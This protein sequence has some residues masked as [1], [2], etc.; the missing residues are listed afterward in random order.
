MSA[1]GG[2]CIEATDRTRHPEARAFR[3]LGRLG[4]SRAI[5]VAQRVAA[6]L[7]IALFAG[8]QPAL[9]AGHSL[10]FFGT[11]TG[12]IDRVKIAI[13]DPLTTSPG[14][15]VDVGAGDFTVELWIKANAAENT[16]P[17][18]AC[19]ANVSWRNGNV[20]I[21]RDRLN[22]DRKFGVSIAGA[23]VVFGIS[24][25]TT[26]SLTLCGTSAVLDGKWHHVAVQRRRSDGNL[27]LFVDGNLEAQGVG[28]GG[29]I[30]YPDGAAPAD[31]N[32][33][34]LVL[35]AEKHD[36]GPAFPSFSGWIDELRVSTKL[37][38]SVSFPRPGAPYV[39]DLYTAALYH[40]DEG[41]GA[42]LY[43]ASGAS[44]GP[45]N[46]QIK[47]GGANDGPAWAPKSPFNVGGIVNN[48]TIA[49]ATF[50]TGFTLPVDIVN[51]EDASG[52]LYIVQQDGRI[53]IIRKGVVLP[54]PFLDISAKIVCCGEQGLLGLAFHPN[55]NANGRFFVYYT[56]AG[57]GALTIERYQRSAANTNL[58]DTAPASVKTLLVIPHPGQSN[59]NGG[60]LAFGRDGYLYAGTGDGGSGDDPPNNA[61]MVSRRLGKLL[62]FDVDQNVNAAPYYGIPPTNPFAGNTCD[63]GNIGQCPEIWAYGLRNPWRWSF[64]RLTGDLFIGDVGQGARE[65]VDFDPW[66]GTA[67]RNYGWRIME[68]NICTPGVNPSCSPP[69]NYAPPIFDYPHPTGFAIIGGYRYRGNAIPALAGAYLYADEVT[70]VIWAATRADNGV[71]TAQ[72]QLLATPAN[73]SAFGEANGGELYVAGH[74]NGTIYKVVPRD[75][76]GDGLPDWWELAYTGSVTGAIATADLDGD[77]ANNLAEYGSRTEPWNAGSV[78]VPPPPVLAAFR[79]GTRTFYLDFDRDGQADQTVD[80]GA[81]GGMPG[82]VALAGRVDNDRRY[83]LVIYRDGFWYADLNR[84]GTVDAVF[85][86]G[87]V[88]G[89]DQPLLADLNGDG[90][91]DLVVYRNGAWHV[92]TTQTGAA[93][94]VYYFGGAS[95][96]IALAGDVDG[97]GIADLVIY[98][99][100]LWFIDTNRDGI[101]DIVVGHGGLAG[102]KPVLFDWDGDGRADLCVVRNGT[103]FVNTR[104]DGS[105]QA[106]FGYGAATDTPLAWRE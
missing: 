73:V 82:D 91:D 41:D 50:A 12:D 57:D 72:Q 1:A 93:S 47:R 39:P 6:L 62:R 90:R 88:V 46:G 101:A 63:G 2:R 60:K 13:D 11:G 23:K 64:D 66:P 25:D 9:A 71:W 75:S 99:N 80:F 78:P 85:A 22:L 7:A 33:V 53:R 105:V 67:G 20:V 44:G 87:G 10:R 69:P 43:D 97:D 83:D 106:I 35:G 4:A 98:R 5:S 70:N 26:G 54:T 56:R 55:Y 81:L 19:G 68:G 27:W 58:A 96:D 37:R 77:G 34:F 61:Q 28:P 21:D 8:A 95:G 18:V 102:D 74:N 86:F 89:V 84:D 24:G 30:S 65:E 51:A 76:D 31:P 104:L 38:Y 42:T 79:N 40:F 17:A 103:W 92:S 36:A 29:D 48:G 32:D 100:G 45:S 14:P 52:R 49:L 59:H 15:P 94:A 16:A 3:S